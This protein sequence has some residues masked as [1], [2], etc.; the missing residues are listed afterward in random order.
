MSNPSSSVLTNSWSTV[1]AL[2][3][4]NASWSGVS[5]S[6][7]N[8]VA[9]DLT[10]VGLSGSLPPSLSL[11]SSLTS[12]KLSGNTFSGSL[13]AQWSV[14]TQLV[15]VSLSTNHLAGSLP[16]AFS[17][18]RSLT[19]LSAS[20]NL[21]T[22][23]IPASWPVG[24]TSLQRLVLSNNTGLCGSIPSIWSSLVSST[25]T[26]LGVVCSLPPQTLG[27]LSLRSAVTV[28]SWPSGLAGWTNATDPCG[29]PSWGGVS[30]TGTLVTG[31]DLSS[32][33]VEGTLPASLSQVSGLQT[34]QLGSNRC[35]GVVL[36]CCLAPTLLM[37]W[38]PHRV[39]PLLSAW[40]AE[41]SAWVPFVS[42]LF[43]TCMFGLQLS[44]LISFFCCG[45]SSCVCKPS[46]C[47]LCLS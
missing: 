41:C 2:A 8:V 14:L 15:L 30:C 33:N 23:T 17:T 5:C 43:F 20:Y 37:P 39:I 12:L 6:G 22:S 27:L 32:Y 29:S 26:G 3:A 1:S 38:L 4:C 28:A 34:L 40:S 42:V 44:V 16:S 24:M 25:N 19:Q 7:T 21:L 46:F 36:G 10:S 45:F 35:V 9:L 31:L 11:M 18:W 47:C 13:P